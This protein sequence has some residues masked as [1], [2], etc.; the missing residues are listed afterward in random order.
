MRTRILCLLLLCTAMSI[1]C[2]AQSSMVYNRLRMI[3]SG[4]ADEVRRELPDLMKEF[5]EDAGV[6]FLNG[7]LTDDASKAIAIYEQITRE[8]PQSEWADDAQLRIVQYYALKKD[9]SRAQRELANF[10]RN[11]PLSEF[12]IHAVELVKTTVGLNSES[13]AKTIASTAKPA[14]TG[15]S[16]AAKESLLVESKPNETNA[17]PATETKAPEKTADAASA[18]KYWGLQVG[19]FASKKAADGEAQKYKDQRMKVDVL[20]KDGKFSV[21]V[22]NYS[23]REAADKSREIIQ[24]QCQCTPYVVEK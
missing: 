13:A 8:Q 14:N 12:L 19:L 22:G 1:P 11:Y 6:M 10:K 21:V 7:V 24:S 17:K 3:I 4:K 9:T 2:T 23:T 5:P 15:A 20:P 16:K 18:K